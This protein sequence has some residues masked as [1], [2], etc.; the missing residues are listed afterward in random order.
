MSVTLVIGLLGGE[1]LFQQPTD[2]CHGI[3]LFCSASPGLV[4]TALSNRTASQDKCCNTAGTSWLLI[5][6]KISNH[7]C[8][9]LNCG[10]Q[11]DVEF[12]TSNICRRRRYD[13]PNYV[14]PSDWCP[15]KEEIRQRDR[16]IQ[17]KSNVKTWRTS[18]T[19]Q[20]TPE[21]IKTQEGGTEWVLPTAQQEAT[22]LTSWFRL[23]ASRAEREWTLL[24]TPPSLWYF[25]AAAPG[26][27]HGIQY[28]VSNFS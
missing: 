6:E 16:H 17:R 12:L 28:G 23:A 2:S 10:P 18:S 19:S 3:T 24:L 21:A 5:W 9:T 15:H 13:D 8:Y 11:K 25:V 7:I 4:L 26:N 20:G 27:W 1:G 22:Q 14:D